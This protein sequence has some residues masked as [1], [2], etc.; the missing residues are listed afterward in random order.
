MCFKYEDIPDAAPEM[1][2]DLLTSFSTV[3]TNA[4]EIIF[5]LAGRFQASE[6]SIQGKCTEVR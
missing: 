5:R 3:Y 1:R 2:T 4:Q 6:R